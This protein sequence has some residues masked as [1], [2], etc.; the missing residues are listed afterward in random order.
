MVQ[1]EKKPDG[2]VINNIML[3]VLQR[4][5]EIA[6]IEI[7]AFL[8][9]LI[10]RMVSTT[11]SAVPCNTFRRLEMQLDNCCETD[12]YVLCVNMIKHN[13]EPLCCICITSIMQPLP[14]GRRRRRGGQSAAR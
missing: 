6:M 3:T 4:S 13:G 11:V 1:T 9:L 14:A 5:T 7:D 2:Y 10:C 12:F 8:F